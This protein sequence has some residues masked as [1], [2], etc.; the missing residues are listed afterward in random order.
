MSLRTARTLLLLAL[1]I[2]LAVACSDHGGDV[3]EPHPPLQ[4]A[5]TSVESLDLIVVVVDGGTV[6][7]DTLAVAPYAPRPQHP[8]EGGTVFG[9]PD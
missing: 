4:F 9:R 1:A 5:Y 8:K 2:P 7:F 6:S 3:L